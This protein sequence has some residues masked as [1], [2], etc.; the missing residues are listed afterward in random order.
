M[1]K[2]GTIDESWREERFGAATVSVAIESEK[3]LL[4]IAI[5]EVGME[6]FEELGY[7]TVKDK[8]KANGRSSESRVLFICLRVSVGTFV[9]VD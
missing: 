5:L 2:S 8:A 3:R 7:V 6:C 4:R 1:Q 9:I